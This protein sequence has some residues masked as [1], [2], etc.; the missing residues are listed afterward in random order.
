MVFLLIILLLLVI[1]I[2]YNIKQEPFQMKGIDNYNRVNIWKY[3]KKKYGIDTARKIMPMSYVFPNEI[4]D[5]IKSPTKEFI[6]KTMRGKGRILGNRSGV[7]LYNDKKK[8]LNDYKDFVIGQEFINNPYLIQSIKFDVRFFL[9]VY[10][11]I[12]IFL[13]LPGYCVFALNP[14]NYNGLD[15]DS[16]INQTGQK[17]SHYDENNLPRTFHEFCDRLTPSQKSILI[18][19]VIRNLKII[20]D[21]LPEF[22][23]YKDRGELN[24]YGIDI[25]ITDDLQP[26]VIEINQNPLLHFSIPWKQNIINDMLKNIRT[27]TFSTSQWVFIKNV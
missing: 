6:L 23:E 26:L 2:N 17:E 22:C 1:L 21:S 11:G 4:N 12:G 18:K 14:F 10:C 25:E 7:F 24:I 9:V 19:R 5:L 8:I 3:V 15:R 20:S 27:R 13:Y 16:K